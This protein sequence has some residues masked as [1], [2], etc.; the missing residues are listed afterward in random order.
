MDWMYS[1]T[2][3]TA[4]RGALDWYPK[5]YEAT[6]PLFRELYDSV[7]KGDET[8]R[9]VRTM[10]FMSVRMGWPGCVETARRDDTGGNQPTNAPLLCRAGR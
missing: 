2:S 1:N 7:E 6:K 9:L 8:R 5:F 10:A 3:T 4:Q